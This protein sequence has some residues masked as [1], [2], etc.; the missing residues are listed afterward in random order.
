M[1]AS[2]KQFTTILD[3]PEDQLTEEKLAEIFGWSP[4]EKKAKAQKAL[5]DLQ[6]KK[7]AAMQKVQ[8]AKQDR[9]AVARAGGMSGYTGQGQSKKPAVAD[10][11]GERR[12]G[13]FA[14]AQRG[15]AEGQKHDFEVG[16]F[17][18]VLVSGPAKGAWGKIADIEGKMHRVKSIGNGPASGTYSKSDIT[19]LKGNDLER[20]AKLKK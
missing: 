7:S 6:A 17:V 16:D 14:F 20:A 19:P 13:D 12:A 9:E 11:H 18:K 5:A 2:F 8:K 4:E 3:L 10:K 15:M 1:K